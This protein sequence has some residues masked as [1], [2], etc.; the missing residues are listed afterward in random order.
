MY[1]IVVVGDSLGTPKKNETTI[2]DTYPCLLEKNLDDFKVVNKCII[3][4]NSSL[5]L[6]SFYEDVEKYGPKIVIIHLGIVD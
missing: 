5:Q 3:N 2:E 6:N 1:K 4:N